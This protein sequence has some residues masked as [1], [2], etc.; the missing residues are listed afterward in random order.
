MENLKIKQTNV[1]NS[2]TNNKQTG[3]ENKERE[4]QD[5]GLRLKDTNY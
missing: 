2:K 5:R 3:I 1:Y 4:G